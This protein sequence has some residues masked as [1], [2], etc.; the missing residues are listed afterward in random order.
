MLLKVASSPFGSYHHLSD[1]EI[2]YVLFDLENTNIMLPFIH[3]FFM[4]YTSFLKSEGRAALKPQLHL[5]WG[6]V[7]GQIS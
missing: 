7:H 2:N 4:R 3:I 5:I 6:A 1:T